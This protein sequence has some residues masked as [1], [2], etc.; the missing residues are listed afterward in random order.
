ME[1]LLRRAP[2]WLTEAALTR[3]AVDTFFRGWARRRVAELDHLTVG[4]SQKRILLGLVHRAQ[5]TRFGQEHDFR[6]IRCVADFRRLVLLR[7][8]AQLWREYW[9]PAFPRLAGATWPGP[10]TSLAVSE[11][12]LTGPF[13]C[14][15]VSADLVAAH[16]RAALTALAFVAQARSTVRLFSGRLFLLGDGTTLH[17]VDAGP[18]PVADLAELVGLP[19]SYL[20]APPGAGGREG[21]TAEEQMRELAQASAALPVTC[22]AGTAERLVR[23]FGQLREFTGRGRVADAWPEL[24]AVVFSRGPLD[25]DRNRLLQAAGV[26]GGT[27]PFL[28]LE[29]SLQPE[30]VVAVEDP[31]HGHLRL[32]A[33]HDVYFEFVPVE[34]LGRPQPDRFEAAEVQVGVPYALALTSPAGLWACL[35]GTVVC[36]ERREPPLLR[37][38]ATGVQREPPATVAPPPARPLTRSAPG[39][40]LRPP[41]PRV[42][43]GL[44]L[45]VLRSLS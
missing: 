21:A 28:L 42:G 36:F 4:R 13:P 3:R 23:L 20:F 26:T 41:H 11:N 22:L 32:L 30:G 45:P 43:T 24:A 39:M 8:P 29:A 15:P 18:R 6:R 37:V 16:R 40:P 38:V 25:P 27:P 5:T 7:T 34:Q 2:R 12:L 33:D 44:T 14:V 31:R 35:V 10:I 9:Q 19:A 1:E 17:P